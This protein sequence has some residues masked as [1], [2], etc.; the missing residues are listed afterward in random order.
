MIKVLKKL[1]IERM[2]LNIIKAIYDKPSANLILNGEQL[3]LLPLKSETR[4]VCLV[5]PLLLNTVLEFQARAISEEQ[6]IK[7]IQRVKEEA[8]LFLFSDD[9]FLYL[10]DPKN[11]TKKLLRIINCFQQS[12]RIQN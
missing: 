7:Q 4:Q 9:M 1:G 3:K 11:S 12:S 8:K 6:E 10:R 5:S 2:F